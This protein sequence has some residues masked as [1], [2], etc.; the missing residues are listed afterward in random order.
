M[1][2]FHA[3]GPDLPEYLVPA[4]VQPIHPGARY[5]GVASRRDNGMWWF[6]FADARFTSG[7]FSEATITL[8]TGD[9]ASAP[10]LLGQDFEWVEPIDEVRSLAANFGTRTW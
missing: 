4:Y 3:P 6:S 2:V 10:L 5:K 9:Y 1:T 7:L 8:F